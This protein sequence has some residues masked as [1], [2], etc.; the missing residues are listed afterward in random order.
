M[1]RAT[2]IQ[3]ALALVSVLVLTLCASS[4]IVMGYTPLPESSPIEPDPWIEGNLTKDSHKSAW[5]MFTYEDDL[6]AEKSISSFKVSSLVDSRK[7][8]C[9]M[10]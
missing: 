1:H 2:A 4:T 6:G 10:N 8:P 5:A 9:P 3:K 7:S